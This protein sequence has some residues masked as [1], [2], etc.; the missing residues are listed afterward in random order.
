M[1]SNTATPADIQWQLDRMDDDATEQEARAAIAMIDASL[2]PAA[3]LAGAFAIELWQEIGAANLAI[4]KERNA[5]PAYGG[6]ICASHDYCDANMVMDSAFRETIGRDAWPEGQDAMADADC[7][8]WNE[9][10]SIA[11]RDYLTAQPA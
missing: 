5:T 2:P 4:V 9:A 10:W 7:A 6:T 1:S 11:K 3:R 8:L